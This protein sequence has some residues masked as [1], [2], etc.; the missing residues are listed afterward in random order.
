MAYMIKKGGHELHFNGLGSYGQQTPCPYIGAT[1]PD[2]KEGMPT[3]QK[4]AI[5]V[6]VV[7][8]L[9]GFSYLVIKRSEQ[10]QM[11]AMPTGV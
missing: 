10:Q 7:G 6:G 9:V 2:K 1:E 5:G 4:V 8:G 11:A 3:W